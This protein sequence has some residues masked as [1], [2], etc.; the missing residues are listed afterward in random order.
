MGQWGA[1]IARSAV[2]TPNYAERLLAGIAADRFARFA[3]PGGVVVKSNHPAFVFGHL[4]LYPARV[5]QLCG[6]PAGAAQAPPR[7]EELFKNGVECVDDP[8]G[9]IYPPMA[10][11]TRHFFESHRLA[12]EAVAAASDETLLAANPAEGRMKELFPSIA[13]AIIFYLDGHAQM[14]LGQVSAWR[15]M[16]NLPAA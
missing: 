14:H 6:K 9:A 15:R 8:T 16:M 2:L 12:S 10:D 4:S 11:I 7:F 13:A 5:L 3:A 1:I